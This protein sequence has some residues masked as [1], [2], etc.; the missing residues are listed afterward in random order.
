MF[1]ALPLKVF[2]AFPICPSTV[3]TEISSCSAISLYFMPCCFA[4]KNIFRRSVGKASIQFQTK[5][6]SS[7]DMDK[8]FSSV[9]YMA[10]STET[11]SWSFFTYFTA[12]FR[13]T[14]YKYPFM[15]PTSKLPTTA[16]SNN[17][18]KICCTISSESSYDSV[19]FSAYRHNG[20]YIH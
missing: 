12:R 1:I 11:F 18:T 5:A 6:S 9:R 2:N 4:I 7:T 10:L 15:F 13:T 20:L 17:Y 14:V 3:L 16:F 8:I 19:I